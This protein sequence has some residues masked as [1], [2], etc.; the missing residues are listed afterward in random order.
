MRS[1]DVAIIGGGVMGS[2]IALHLLEAEPGTRVIVLERDPSYTRASSALAMGGIRQQFGSAVSVG[3]VR[4]SI[5]FWHTFDD[6]MRERGIDSRANFRQRG[7]L[8]LVGHDQVPI[9]EQR[10]SLEASLGAC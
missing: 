5:P 10:L 9:F 8:F 7:Y 1:A 3:L 2:S 6:S 4:L